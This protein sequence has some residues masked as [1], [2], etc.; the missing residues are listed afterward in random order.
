MYDRVHRYLQIEKYP[1]NMSQSGDTVASREG[2][3]TGQRRVVHGS[4]VY[5]K[6]LL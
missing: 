3:R 5:F 4:C 6:V 2:M 1:K